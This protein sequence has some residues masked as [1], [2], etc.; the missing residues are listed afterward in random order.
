MDCEN[1]VDEEN[2]INT[3]QGFANNAER[4]YKENRPGKWWVVIEFFLMGSITGYFV[5]LWFGMVVNPH[6]RHRID[7]MMMDEFNTGIESL[8]TNETLLISY[9]YKQ[10]VPHFYSKW[11]SYKNEYVGAKGKGAMTIGQAVAAAAA[12]PNVFHPFIR[13]D[14]NGQE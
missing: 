2:K 8:I 6:T 4:R 1:E 9:D 14:I 10:S 11:F 5:P 13:T 3:F 12:R 7:K